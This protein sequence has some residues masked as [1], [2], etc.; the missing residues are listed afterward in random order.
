MLKLGK[1]QKQTVIGSEEFIKS[2]GFCGLDMVSKEQ[3]LQGQ[4]NTSLLTKSCFN[5]SK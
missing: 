1:T 2:F 4:K 3:R 5:L